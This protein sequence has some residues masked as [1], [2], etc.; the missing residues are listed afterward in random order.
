M[1]KSKLQKTQQVSRIGFV[2]SFIGLLIYCYTGLTNTSQN[3][4]V[5]FFFVPGLILWTFAQAYYLHT[6]VI[7]HKKNHHN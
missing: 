3:P 4:V 6:S 1:K 5:V 2:L 7:Q